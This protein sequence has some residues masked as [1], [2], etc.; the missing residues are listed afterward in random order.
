MKRKPL[1]EPERSA[2][3]VR[4]WLDGASMEELTAEFDVSAVSI[5]LELHRLGRVPPLFPSR[6]WGRYRSTKHRGPTRVDDGE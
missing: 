6:Y 5:E 3:L 1:W 4:L 2:R